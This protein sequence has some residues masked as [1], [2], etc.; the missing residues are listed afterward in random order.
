MDRTR[1]PNPRPT[2]KKASKPRDFDPLERGKNYFYGNYFFFDFG[3][4]GLIKIVT[5]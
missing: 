2:A 3:T 4:S 1:A 5:I